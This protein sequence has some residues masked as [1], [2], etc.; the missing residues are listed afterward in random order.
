MVWLSWYV[1]FFSQEQMTALF[2]LCVCACKCVFHCVHVRLA[3]LCF[4]P[5]V[6]E[7]SV[8]ALRGES[9]TQERAPAAFSVRQMDEVY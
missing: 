3:P 6:D 7:R 5:G 4:V 2:F 8:H 9:T 1:V